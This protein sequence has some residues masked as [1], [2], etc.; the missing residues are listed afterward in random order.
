MNITLNTAEIKE[1]FGEASHGG[2]IGR[3]A[4]ILTIGNV[5]ENGQI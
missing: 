4:Q 2:S 3:L 5:A 1:I